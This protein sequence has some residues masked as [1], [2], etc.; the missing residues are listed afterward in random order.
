MGVP[1]GVRFLP[2]LEFAILTAVLSWV[3]LHGLVVV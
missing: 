3:T 1:R 2:L